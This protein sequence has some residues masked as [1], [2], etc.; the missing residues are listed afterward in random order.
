MFSPVPW[1]SLVPVLSKLQNP[2]QLFVSWV[3]GRGFPSDTIQMFQFRCNL[4]RTNV[5]CEV[6][7]EAL[8]LCHRREVEGTCQRQ[9]VRSVSRN[10]NFFFFCL[11]ARVSLAAAVRR[12]LGRCHLGVCVRAPSAH[13]PVERGPCHRTASAPRGV[14]R[15]VAALPACFPLPHTE[16]EWRPPGRALARPLTSHGCP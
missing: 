15:G 10:Q 6:N 1:I 12:P 8:P 9:V 14:L 2:N 16:S 11:E 4:L 5:K 13:R 7:A 3:P